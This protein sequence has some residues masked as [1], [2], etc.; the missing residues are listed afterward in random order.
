MVIGSWLLSWYAGDEMSLQN[1]ALFSFQLTF[2]EWKM[3]AW[4]LSVG[5]GVG[6]K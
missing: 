4:G 2:A 5:V 1:A 3:D 6:G